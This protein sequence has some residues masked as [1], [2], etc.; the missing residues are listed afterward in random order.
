MLLKFTDD[1]VNTIENARL[2]LGEIQ[3]DISSREPY[4]GESLVLDRLYAQSVL[5][6]GII[7]YLEN[8]DNKNPRED[9]GLLMCLR[10]M[11]DKNLCRK[12]VNKIKDKTNYHR[13]I[14][15][16]PAPIPMIVPVP[17]LPPI[18]SPVPT[19]APAPT[20][21]PTP[22]PTPYPII[23]EEEDPLPIDPNTGTGTG[24]S[25]SGTGSS[26]GTGTNPSS[27]Y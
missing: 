22:M 16:L 17:V 2:L 5:I 11:A 23:E 9:E 14:N 12:P 4:L 18:P 27:W 3:F 10:S 26:A 24:S 25:T 7:D 19:P 15:P 1:F 8:S 6:S 20:P 13:Q 21:D